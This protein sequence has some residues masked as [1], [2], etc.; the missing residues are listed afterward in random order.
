MDKVRNII[1]KE[2]DELILND[3]QP[4]ENIK[5]QSGSF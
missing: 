1:L 2:G 4:F 5:D 3:N